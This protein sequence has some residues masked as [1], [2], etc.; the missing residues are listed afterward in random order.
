MPLFNEETGEIGDGEP[1][2]EVCSQALQERLEAEAMLRGAERELTKQIRA[3]NT[4]RAELNRQRTETP[5]GR[6]AKA[7]GRY[8]IKVCGKGPNTKVKDKRLKSVFDRLSDGYD[9]SYIARAIDG[10]GAAASTSNSETERLALIRVMQEAVRRLSK[11]D[12]QELRQIYKD[13]LKNVTRYDDLELI[14]RDETKLER[15]HELA[16]RVNA[17]TLVG[18]A[19]LSEF[20]GKHTEQT[21]KD[22]PF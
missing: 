17:P 20:E 7:L 12:A 9:P 19:W 3:N 1:G 8:W 13:A 11:E 10:A 22:T 6:V 16:E 4:L 14:C 2:C 18:P 15:F 21:S 5:Q